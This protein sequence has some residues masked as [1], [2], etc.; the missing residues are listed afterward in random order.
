MEVVSS[1]FKES[2]Y[3]TS[4]KMDAKVSFEILDEE[5]MSDA[6]VSASSGAP[7]SRIEQ[8]INKNRAMSYHYATFEE[9]YFKL[10]GSMKI[11]PRPNEG[12]SEVGF[13][14]SEI[15]DKYGYF[16]TVNPQL[17]F[18]FSKPFSVLGLTI[19]FDTI[20][21]ETANHFNIQAFNASGG[22]VKN[23][24]Y[25]ENTNSIFTINEPVEDFTKLQLTIYQWSKGKR[26][27]KVTEV[28]FGIVQEFSGSELI[29][30][31]VLEEMDLV[32]TTVPSNEM[33]FTLDNSDRRFNLLNPE[34]IYRFIRARQEVFVYIGLQITETEGDNEYVP[35]GKFYLTEWQTDEGA[36]T[37]T[38]TGRDIFDRLETEEYTTSLKNTTL[39]ALAEDILLKSKVTHYRID[40]KLLGDSTLGFEEPIGAREGLQNIAIAGRSVIYQ[41]REGTLVIERIEPLTTSTGFITFTGSDIYTGLSSYPEVSNDYQMQSIDFENTFAEPQVELNESIYSLIFLINDG[42]EN[43]T[44]VTFINPIEHTNGATYKIENPLINDELQAERLADWMFTEYNMRAY[45]RANWRQ[46]PALE[47][48]DAIMIENSFGVT[49]KGRIVKQEFLFDGALSGNTE[50]VGGV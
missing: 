8:V 3:A 18:N 31:T 34:G 38:F 33:S 37:T 25:I 43:G 5:A 47:C 40:S 20:N 26:R 22:L 19:S 39:Y 28:N 7:H 29:D 9:N 4:R 16:N 6:S 21:E 13:W 24:D 14:S 11:P 35:I 10:D 32:G 27:A 46:N 2:I 36:L 12:N 42:T 1:E 41:D 49:K 45:Y 50:A 17:T 44:E 30:L 23:I 48:G 15:T